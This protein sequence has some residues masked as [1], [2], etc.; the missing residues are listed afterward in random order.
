[1]LLSYIRNREK[2]S[3][4]DQTLKGGEEEK[5]KVCQSSAGYP[6][7]TMASRVIRYPAGGTIPRQGGKAFKLPGGP[8][9]L[10]G[11]PEGAILSLYKS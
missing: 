4:D 2:F 10:H 11:D 7:Q 9:Q 6:A 8:I 5:K 1:M 3:L